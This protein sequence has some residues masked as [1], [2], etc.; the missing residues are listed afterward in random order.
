MQGWL[1]VE[2]EEFKR[3]LH[4]LLGIQVRMENYFNNKGV[5]MKDRVEE[6]LNSNRAFGILLNFEFL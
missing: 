4:H 2:E 6:S 5:C 1:E 3:E